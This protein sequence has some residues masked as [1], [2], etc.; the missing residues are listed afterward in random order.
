MTTKEPKYSTSVTVSGGRQGHAVSDDGVLDVQ[1]RVPKR[2]GASDGTNPEQL[3]A[4]AWAACF[5][6][7]LN[8]VAGQAGIDAAESTVRVEISQG[9]DGGYGLSARIFSSIP[10]ADRAKVQELAEAAHQ[11]CPYSSAT[12][13]NIDVEVIADS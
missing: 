5:G 8:Y 4:A 10:G 9:A 12:R 13:G 2:N 6:S 1:L 11:V 3:F 7:A